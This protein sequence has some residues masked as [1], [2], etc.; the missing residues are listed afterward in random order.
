MTWSMSLVNSFAFDFGRGQPERRLGM[1]FH[2]VNGTMYADYGMRKVVPEGQRMDGLKPPA[3]SIPPSPGHEREWL[4]SIK[5]RKSPS[6]CPDYHCK[7]DVPL[8]LANL[9]LKLG[10]AIRFDPL[11]EKI[12]DDEEAARLTRPEYR[13][14]W[15]FPAEYA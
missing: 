13:A 7:V 9:S 10:R 11:A 1:Y 14:P 15:K 4:D 3:V 12:V 2:G 6:C 5:T 8:V